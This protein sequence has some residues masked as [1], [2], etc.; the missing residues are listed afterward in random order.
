MPQ[1]SRP[2]HLFKD[3]ATECLGFV[4]LLAA[5]GAGVGET[6]PEYLSVIH[7]AAKWLSLH[8]IGWIQERHAQDSALVEPITQYLRALKRLEEATDKNPLSL[9]RREHGDADL[10]AFLERVF[11]RAP[12]ILDDATLISCYQCYSSAGRDGFNREVAKCLVEGSRDESD[13]DIFDDDT[14]EKARASLVAMFA[15]VAI[16]DLPALNESMHIIVGKTLNDCLREVTNLQSSL[17]DS[18]VHGTLAW[19]ERRFRQGEGLLEQGK[20]LDGRKGLVRLTEACEAFSDA[21]AVYTPERHRLQWMATKRELGNAQLTQGERLEG[22]QGSD[23]LGAA[24]QTFEQ[25]LEVCSDDD[26]P[27]AWAQLVCSRCR[28][29]GQYAMWHLHNAE[30]KSIVGRAEQSGYTQTMFDAHAGIEDVLARLTPPD[31]YPEEVAL[32]HNT[33]GCL[34][35][36]ATELQVGEREAQEYAF[37]HAVQIFSSLRDIYSRDVRPEEWADLQCQLGRALYSQFMRLQNCLAVANDRGWRESDAHSIGLMLGALDYVVGSAGPHQED[38]Q[39]VFDRENG[40][41][42]LF[43]GAF[44]LMRELFENALEILDVHSYPAKWAAVQYRLGKVLYD[45]VMLYGGDEKEN[46]E[47]ELLERAHETC[48]NAL[49][50]FTRENNAL[51]WAK[52]KHLEGSVCLQQVFLRFTEEELYAKIRQLKTAKVS[53]ENALAGFA[54]DEWLDVRGAIAGQLEVARNQLKRLEE[55]N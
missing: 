34:L 13:S 31:K 7:A 9:S 39:D 2:G 37:K 27:S 12:G 30:V 29:D 15:G 28:A 52:V 35:L 4:S 19:A 1:L 17:R 11:D 45:E 46:G 24:S 50:I 6:G 43:D 20:R 44:T 40:L 5:I 14:I 18:P 26:A 55:L 42:R 25:A 16:R 21:L 3:K 8:G 36:M 22:E 53:L 23:L 54:G 32:A 51:A 33:R 41:R 49:N 10:I 38:R 47:E 48:V